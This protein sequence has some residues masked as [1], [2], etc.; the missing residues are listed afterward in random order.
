MNALLAFAALNG[1]L[2]IALGAFAAHGASPE[3][4]QLLQTGGHYQLVHAVF[5]LVVALAPTRI[6][7]LRLAGWIAATGG[8]IFSASLAAIALASLPVAGAVA[9]VGGFLMIMG[10]L[11]LLL[12]AFRS[13]PT[14]D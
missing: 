11:L 3:A 1:A 5:A 14:H 4:R 9:P 8:L 13:G 6:P 2:A 7:L 12:V 10:W